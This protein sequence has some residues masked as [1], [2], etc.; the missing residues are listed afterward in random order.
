MNFKA[1]DILSSVV[2]GFFL[3]IVL[4]YFL[5][6][7]YDKDMIVPYTASAYLLGYLM[8]AL[9][10]WM[11]DFYF[12]TWGGN[13]AM[14]LLRGHDVWKAR[15]YSHEQ[16]SKLLK[17]E[18]PNPAPSELELFSIAMR[19]TNQ[20]DSKIED[21]NTA[22][23]FSRAILT[24]VILASILFFIRNYHNVFYDAFI[25]LILS[26]AWLRCKQRN[27]YYAREVLNNYVKIKSG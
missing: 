22:Y 17:G 24:C 18:C 8:N 5:N 19:Y 15:F 10:S 20:K 2:P 1:Y 21:L 23:V 25:L 13:P 4:L 11:E 12:F 7:P 26:I 6:L 27:Y 3:G 9:S 14:Q 16:V